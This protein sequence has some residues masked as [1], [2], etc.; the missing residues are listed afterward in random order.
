MNK[1]TLFFI[2]STIL[3][4]MLACSNP[5]EVIESVAKEGEGTS[6]DSSA[7][8]VLFQDDFSQTDSGWDRTSDSFLTTDYLDGRYQ[9]LINDTNFYGW[10]NPGK[11]FSDTRIKT[12]AEM[13]NGAT[14]TEYGIICRYKDVKNFYVGLISADGY[15]AIIKNKNGK[16]ELVGM[17]YMQ[18]SPKI[19]LGL[20]TNQLQFDCI[21]DTLTLYAN[22]EILAEVKDSDFP[23][24]D[25]GLIASTYDTPG[26]EILFDNFR[27]YRP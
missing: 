10:A 25:V 27:V 22:G 16:F 3:F 4:L 23:N 17:D 21:D 13:V 5:V 9:I 20:S 8:D 26:A 18:D 11:V 12:E 2:V 6:S 19:N 14:D 24:G 1:R 15:Y 7:N